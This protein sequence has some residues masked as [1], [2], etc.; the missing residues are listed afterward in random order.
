MLTT[1]KT[2]N[3]LDRPQKPLRFVGVYSV[4][5]VFAVCNKLQIFQPVIASVEVFMVNLKATFNRAYKRLPQRAVNRNRSVFA[6]LAQTYNLIVFLIPNL[7]RS[8][9]LV[10]NPCAPVFD[11][12]NR[13]YAGVQKRCD[14]FQFGV[15]RQHLLGCAHL[16]SGKLFAP[17]YTSHF[18]NVANLIQTFVTRYCPPF[19]HKPP[20]FANTYNKHVCI[21]CK[22]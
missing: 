7:N 15:L 11:R 12:H 18:G 22:Q 13:R 3:A 16:L 17:R 6:V 10:A 20:L 5:D 4:L 19:S 2:F 1:N 8:V 14:F 9:R 21:E